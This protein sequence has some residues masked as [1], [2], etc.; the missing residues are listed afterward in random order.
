M[1][2]KLHSLEFEIEGKETTVKEEFQNFKD[3][4][5]GELLSKI[6]VVAPTVTSVSAAPTKQ[7]HLVTDS[8]QTIKNILPRKT[9][10]NSHAEKSSKKSKVSASKETLSIDKNL[11]LREKDKK[12]FKDFYG[13]KQPKSAMDFNTLVIYYLAKILEL[14]KIN[15]SQ[16][17]TCYKEV[18]KKVPVALTQSLR[19]TASLKGYIDTAHTDDLKLSTRGENFVEQDL[20]NKKSK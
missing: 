14:N 8:S 9:E 15:P 19:D 4:I 3:F 5:T 16:V 17:Y 11:N 2:F 6:N 7:H 12:S 20:P 1:K 10:T 18:G 13:E